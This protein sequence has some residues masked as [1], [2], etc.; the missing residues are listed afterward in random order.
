LELDHT[1]SIRGPDGTIYSIT[2]TTGAQ[3][4]GELQVIEAE[5]VVSGE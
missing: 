4:I 1:C 2:G 3:R 5:I